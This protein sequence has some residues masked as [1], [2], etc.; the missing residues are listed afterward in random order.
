MLLNRGDRIA[1]ESELGALSD[2]SP[3]TANK[4]KLNGPANN[5][6]PTSAPDGLTANN[7]LFCPKIT[8]FIKIFSL[9]ICVGNYS[10]SGCST[11]VSC[12]GIG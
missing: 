2:L 7:S 8:L 6:I 10:G 9:I 12:S 4:R 5:L 11:A 3:Q 1:S